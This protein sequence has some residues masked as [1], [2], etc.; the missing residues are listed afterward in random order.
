MN[1]RSRPPII[2]A[3]ASPRRAELL[4]RTGVPFTVVTPDN[5]EELLNGHP[6]DALAIR[7]AE[8]KAAAVAARHPHALVIAADTIVVLDHEIFGKPGTLDEATQ[9]LGRL[10]GRHHDVFTAVCLLHRPFDT[11]LSFCERTRVWMQPL[12]AGQIREYF[13]KVNP[14]DKAGAYAIQ[15][16]GDGIVHHI[17]GSYSNVV[18]LPVERLLAT[19]ERIGIPLD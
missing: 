2:L 18:G 11:R 6:P 4:R 9:M 8:R 13:A 5:V 14:L 16:H 15:E 19:L 3:S 10:A 17:E 7:N 1:S 12:S